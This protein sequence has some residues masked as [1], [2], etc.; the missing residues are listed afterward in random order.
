MF[1]ESIII[2]NFLKTASGQLIEQDINY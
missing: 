2:P 1:T